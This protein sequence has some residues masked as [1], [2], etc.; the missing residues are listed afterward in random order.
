MLQ[1]IVESPHSASTFN[2]RLFKE[3]ERDDSIMIMQNETV[4]MTTS[5]IM[6]T[7]ALMAVMDTMIRRI[8]VTMAMVMF[9]IH[10]MPWCSALGPLQ[11][12]NVGIYSV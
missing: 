6:V 3:A 1:K 12:C 10:T 7:V 8:M 9:M 2:W 11:A 4:T 5:L